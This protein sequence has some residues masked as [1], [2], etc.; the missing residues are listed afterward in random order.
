MRYVL[1]RNQAENMNVK[2]WM[3]W[4]DCRRQWK[5]LSQTTA[6]QCA[7]QMAIEYRKDG[8]VPVLTIGLRR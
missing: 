6:H 1:L 4:I 5:P 7:N 3:H 2:P 8:N